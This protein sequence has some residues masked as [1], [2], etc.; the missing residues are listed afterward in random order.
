MAKIKDKTALI[1]TLGRKQERASFLFIRRMSP[2]YGGTPA[3]LGGYIHSLY[4]WKNRGVDRAVGQ[5]QVF[6][7][8]DGPSPTYSLSKCE[9]TT[10][11]LKLLIEFRF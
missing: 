1:N 6:G 5:C 7:R 11:T 8:I 2:K 9:K 3:Y 10:T 4:Y